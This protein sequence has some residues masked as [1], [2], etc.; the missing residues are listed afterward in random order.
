MAAVPASDGGGSLGGVSKQ[1]AGWAKVG[2]QGCGKAGAS[3][4]DTV[5]A[6]AMVGT[7]VGIAG[8]GR[9]AAPEATVRLALGLELRLGP[10]A[11]AKLRA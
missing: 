9:D 10:G 8:A 11:G 1:G 6:R 5:V 2:A 7:T 3:G 4:K